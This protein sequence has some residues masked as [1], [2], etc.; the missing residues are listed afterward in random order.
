MEPLLLSVLMVSSHLLHLLLAMTALLDST[1]LTS[2]QLISSNAHQVLTQL[3]ISKYAQSARNSTSVLIETQFHSYLMATS[4]LKAPQLNLD[5]E[6]A[7]NAKLV[8]LHLMQDLVS[9]AITHRQVQQNAQYA[10]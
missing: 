1:V 5:V 4:V 9:Q 7:G 3:E 6:V 10:L 8:A 2:M